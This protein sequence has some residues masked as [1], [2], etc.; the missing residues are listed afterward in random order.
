MDIEQSFVTFKSTLHSGIMYLRYDKSGFGNM[1]VAFLSLCGY[2]SMQ[3]ILRKASL[4]GMGLTA[5][6]LK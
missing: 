2:C 3:N 5:D 1:F 6:L 4:P